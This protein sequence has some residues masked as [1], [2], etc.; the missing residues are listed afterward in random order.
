[1][2]LKLH[3]LIEHTKL[4]VAQV[5]ANACY[6]L[7]KHDQPGGVNAAFDFGDFDHDA[8]DPAMQALE[9]SCLKAKQRY[10]I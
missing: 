10:R 4:T 9:I 5:H 3:L 7:G 8:L 2:T 1:M 6:N